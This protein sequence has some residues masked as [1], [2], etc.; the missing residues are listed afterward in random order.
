MAKCRPEC[1]VPVMGMGT[2]NKNNKIYLSV[3]DPIEA[4]VNISTRYF[5]SIEPAGVTTTFNMFDRPVDQL[6]CPKPLCITSGTLYTDFLVTEG[7]EEGDPATVEPTETTYHTDAAAADYVTGAYNMYVTLTGPGTY[8][9]TVSIQ[10]SC[11]LLPNATEFTQTVVGTESDMYPKEVLV[12]SPLTV[13]EHILPSTDC[14]MDITVSVLPILDDGQTEVNSVGISSISMVQDVS[15]YRLNDV[16]AI[17]CIDEVD[18]PMDVD[19]TDATCLGQAPDDTSVSLEATVTAQQISGNFF[20][21]NPLL[22]KLDTVEAFSIKCDTRTISPITVNGVD[23]VGV[24]LPHYYEE[25]CG[26]LSAYL[27]AC[28]AVT[29]MLAYDSMIA[30]NNPDLEVFKLIT[31]ETTGE[32]YLYFNTTHEGLEVTFTYPMRR[33][34]IRYEGTTDFVEGRQIRA[35]IPF[36]YT[37]GWEGYYISDNAFVSSMPFGWSTTEDTPMEFTIVFKRT[38]NKLFE[39]VL[40]QDDKMSQQG[41]W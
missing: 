18:L 37:N 16:I 40:F 20:R 2:Q 38:G 34:A 10:D 32:S 12:Q 5:E 3:T 1:S 9:V 8:D 39:V 28:D 33:E 11:S 30:W 6:N 21:L 4:C 35:I 13:A 15:D 24:R 36:S 7:A 25:E 29:G 23:L 41:E 26:F 17:T 27:P 19:L 14:G 31:D 22:H